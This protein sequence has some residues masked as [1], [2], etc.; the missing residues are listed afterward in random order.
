MSRARVGL[1]VLFAALTAVP[2]AGAAPP[3][4][5]P[6]NLTEERA[7][8]ILLAADGVR[9]WVARYPSESLVTDAEYST[10]YR[11]WTVKAWSGDA[12]QIVLG[13]VDDLTGLVKDAWT[14]PQVAWPMARGGG[15]VFGGKRL[16]SLPVW[17]GFCAVFFLGLADLRRL[18]SVRNLDLLVL[19]SLTVSFW[20]FNDGRIFT[21]VP[22]VYPVLLYLLGRMLWIGVRAGPSRVVRP[23]LPV[24]LLVAATIFLVGF[25]IGLVGDAAVID[26]GYSGVIGAHRIANGQAPYGHFPEASRSSLR[27]RGPQRPGRAAHPDERSL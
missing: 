11:D 20:F 18:R 25:R 5:P 2:A 23:L 6:P 21:S 8:D 22:L 1:A 4:L 24:W 27:P 14:G 3:P 12:G 15:H 26:V 7:V 17:L 9:A 16:N 10:E 19:V 13:R